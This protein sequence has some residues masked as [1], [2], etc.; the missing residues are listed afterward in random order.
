MTLAGPCPR[1]ARVLPHYP[2]PLVDASV[3]TVTC[4]V[5]AEMV[6][7]IA[8]TGDE[9]TNL[10]LE[11][12]AGWGSPMPWGLCP[13]GH[14]YYLPLQTSEVKPAQRDHRRRRPQKAKEQFRL[15]ER[16]P[17]CER[18][19]FSNGNTWSWRVCVRK[20]QSRRSSRNTM[21]CTG[22]SSDF[23]WFLADAMCTR[24][25]TPWSR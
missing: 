1:Q 15:V 2:Q 21:H 7:S 10:N 9:G 23:F 11:Q 5:V 3:Y 6:F 19:R 17:I 22:V 20:A 14:L 16:R 4:G 12:S 24:L 25:L 8:T 18:A 13:C